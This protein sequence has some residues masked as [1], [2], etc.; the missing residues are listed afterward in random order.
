MTPKEPSKV[1]VVLVIVIVLFWLGFIFDKI[2]I[3]RYSEIPS[4]LS[5]GENISGGWVRDVPDPNL[6]LD[7]PYQSNNY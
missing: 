1:F 4:T 7:M 2:V 3:Q 5:S 6:K